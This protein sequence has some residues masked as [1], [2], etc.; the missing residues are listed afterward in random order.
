VHL[1]AVGSPPGPNV[2]QRSLAPLA[3]RGFWRED[4]A[5]RLG[6]LNEARDEVLPRGVTRLWRKWEVAPEVD[7]RPRHAE[8]KLTWVKE[9]RWR[10]AAHQQV[11]VRREADM[12]PLESR[13]S[14]K[15]FGGGEEAH[16]PTM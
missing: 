15:P 9:E 12:H 4:D 13:R 8:R 16:M 7:T 2:A 1:Q 5:L 10:C 3:E 14:S 11:G 6:R